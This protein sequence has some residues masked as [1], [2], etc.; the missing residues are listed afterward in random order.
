[1][2]RS[3]LPENLQR[4]RHAAGLTQKSLALAA[5]LPRATLA[6]LEQGEAN[7]RLDTLLAVAAA[8][9]V[10]L[11]ELVAAPPRQ[12]LYKVKTLDAREYRD[13]QGRYISRLLSPIASRGVQIQ[14]VTL[15]P[16]CSAA[17][18]PHPRGSQEFFV[19]FSGEAT[20]VVDGDEVVVEAGSL[21][22]FPGHLPH[23]YTNRGAVPAEGYSL[24]ILS[25]EG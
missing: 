21:V 22:Q 4:L 24:I 2:S 23:R 6:S 19:V 16:K 25:L 8:L 9:Q 18:R 13:D 20:L 17:G 5:N 3:Y 1:M 15:M 12:R 10:G 11:D 7:P 14:R